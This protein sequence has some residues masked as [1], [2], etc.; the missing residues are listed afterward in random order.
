MPQLRPKAGTGFARALPVAGLL[1]SL[2]CNGA[3]GAREPH[4]TTTSTESRPLCGGLDPGPA[5]VRRVNRLEYDNTVRDL[6]GTTLTPA[7]AF[8]TEERRLG[9]DDNGAALSAPP[10]LVEQ[11]LKAAEALAQDA[12]DNHWS[13]LSP[14]AT[15]AAD[16]D[17]C[18]QTFIAT[19]GAKA[20]RRPLDADDTATLTA[21]F[22]AGKATDLKTGI[23]LVIETVLQAP[24]FL[25][26]VEM[27]AAPQSSD[28]KVTVKDPTTGAVTGQTQVVRLDDWEMASRLSYLL[29]RSMPDDVLTAA[30]AAGQLHDDDAI[31]AQAA[32]MLA[33]PRAR[34]TVVDFHDQWLRLGEID[35]VEKEAAVF[36]A[37]TPA[38]AGLMRTEAETFLDDVVWNGDGTLA[39]LFGAPYTFANATLASYYGLSGPNGSSFVRVDLDP[40]QRAGVLT[41]GGLLALLAKSNQTSPVHRGKFVREQILCQPLPPPPANLQITPPELSSTLTTRERFTQHAADPYCA[42]CHHLMDPI[43]LG[44]ENFDGAGLFRATENGQ[45]VD[46]SGR[47]DDAGDAT[48]PFNGPIELGQRLAAS[49][50]ARACVA[51]QWFRYGYGRAETDGD[52]CSLRALDSAFAAGGYRVLDL[53]AA[54]ANTDAF[55]YRR[56]T[57]AVG[58]AP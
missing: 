27:G 47:L 17:G 50:E 24:R 42:G 31:A 46:A 43:G 1:V 25:Y 13:A 39:A 20:Y 23:R 48:G 8:P 12:V 10:Q 21:V 3:I 18:G 26:R 5:Y 56:V 45:P 19:F 34:A 22:N 29:W 32:R 30:A 15:N 58:G 44:F 41:Q 36:P 16:V 54:L 53:V 33:D 28:P 2:G 6:L 49:G 4:P 9:F 40:G 52:G 55:R 14:C 51:T 57:P 35:G 11:Y 7:T 37:F 38:I